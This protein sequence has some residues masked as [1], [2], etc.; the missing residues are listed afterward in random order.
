MISELDINPEFESEVEFLNLS[1]L[2]LSCPRNKSHMAGINKPGLS[3]LKDEEFD[4]CNTDHPPTHLE[5]PNDCDADKNC[6]RYYERGDYL[7]ASKSRQF[8]FSE[9]PVFP[10][11]HVIR[12]IQHY[13]QLWSQQNDTAEFNVFFV[14]P[15]KNTIST[16]MYYRIIHSIRTNIVYVSFSSGVVLSGPDV[17]SNLKEYSLSVIEKIKELVEPGLK[18]CL[19]GHS[20]GAT[21]SMVVAYHC[22]HLD[23]DFFEHISVVA[24]GAINLFD[25]DNDFKNIPKIRSYL[26]ARSTSTGIFVDPFCVRGDRSKFMYSPAKLIFK[27]EVDSKI[28]VDTTDITFTGDDAV[29]TSGRLTVNIDQRFHILHGLD[30]DY[31]PGLLNMA[32]RKGGR[33]RKRK[34]SKAKSLRKKYG[35]I[36]R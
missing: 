22:F 35:Y 8:K 25:P 14:T 33:S 1:N 26:S 11:K 23:P 28:E 18:I 34:R 31:V 15:S 32:R 4:K 24:L 13:R 9:I 29:I 10:H 16:I 3:P 7:C 5:D 20:M 2:S 27:V 6:F 19:C 30:S 17:L 12:E 21:L 36:T